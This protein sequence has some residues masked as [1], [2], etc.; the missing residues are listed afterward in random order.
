MTNRIL[1]DFRHLFNTQNFVLFRVFI[2]GLIANSGR[3]MV[4][5]L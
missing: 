5:K 1:T 3:G 2:I 4:T